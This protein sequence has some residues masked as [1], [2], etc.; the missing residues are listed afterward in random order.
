MTDPGQFNG[1]HRACCNEPGAA[2]LA[3]KRGHLVERSRKSMSIEIKSSSLAATRRVALLLALLAL[4]ACRTT[5]ENAGAEGSALGMLAVVLLVPTEMAG[6]SLRDITHRHRHGG[7]VSLDDAYEA[8]YGV[9]ISSPDVDPKTGQ[10]IHPSPELLYG[11]KTG[12][13]GRMHVAFRHLAHMYGLS[14]DKYALCQ[15]V[16]YRDNRTYL[17]VS[18]VQLKP[19][20][21]GAWVP[22]NL[23]PS[24]PME[25]FVPNENTDTVIDWVAIDRSLVDDDKIDAYLLAAAV[26]SILDG[27]HAPDYW[28]VSKQWNDGELAAVMAISEQRALRMLHATSGPAFTN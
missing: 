11:R 16:L 10:L 3:M 14:A 2:S 5:S 18:V 9:H 22:M 19:G 27:Q 7:Y 25:W 12:A 17:L 23:H 4:A 26:Q 24:D 13:V 21:V 8:A 1:D 28:S 15:E 6:D 20:H